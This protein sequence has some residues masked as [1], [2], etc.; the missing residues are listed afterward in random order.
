VYNGKQVKVSCKTTKDS[1]GVTAIQQ[2]VKDG[3]FLGWS[4][5]KNGEVK[6]KIGDIVQLKNDM[7]LYGVIDIETDITGDSVKVPDTGSF[8]SIF[9]AILGTSLLGGGSYTI[10]R[11]YRKI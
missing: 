6:Y 10:Y 5:T 7:T 1:C 9:A 3:K 8:I 11:K 4:T 2:K